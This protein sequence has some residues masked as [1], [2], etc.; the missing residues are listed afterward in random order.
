M[1]G[2]FLFKTIPVLK[3]L[4]CVRFGRASKGNPQALAGE[5]VIYSFKVT[6]GRLSDHRKLN[7]C[8]V[9]W[10]QAAL[11]TTQPTPSLAGLKKATL[12]SHINMEVSKP[13]SFGK[14]RA[15]RSSLL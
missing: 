6:I 2:S 14:N 15:S 9:Y 10:V 8:L 13:S 12:L 1:N 11:C 4:V 5:D 7:N 3:K